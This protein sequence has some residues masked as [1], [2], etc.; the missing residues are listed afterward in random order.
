MSRSKTFLPLLALLVA[1]TTTAQ[2]Q[3]SQTVSRS[4]ALTIQPFITCTGTKDID[5][6]NHRATDGFLQTSATNYAEVVCS[7]DPGNMLSISFG[8]PSQMVNDQATSF[9]LPIGYGSLSAYVSDNSTSFD[10]RNGLGGDITSSGNITVRLGW[11]R[12]GGSGD[13]LVTVNVAN[14]RRGSYHAELTVT[15]AVQ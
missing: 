10:P 9:P 2:A 5:F 11:P 13:E 14:A 12:F 8:L 15:V 1:V 7:T 4:M 6:G 3:S